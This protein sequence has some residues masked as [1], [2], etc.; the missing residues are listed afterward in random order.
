MGSR[1]ILYLTIAASLPLFAGYPIHIG[2][3]DPVGTATMIHAEG[4]ETS[5]NK[6]MVDGHPGPPQER[7]TAIKVD[8]RREILAANEQRRATR[9]Q[10][11]LGKGTCRVDG[12]VLELPPE[13]SIVE[14]RREAG[15]D[16][17]LKDGFPL[18]E[19][20]Q[21][22]LGL[23]VGLG[24]GKDDDDA[25]YGTDKPREI[26][27]SW[28]VNV[29]NILETAGRAAGFTADPRNVTGKTVFQEVVKDHGVDCI[30]LSIHVDIRKARGAFYL[31]R[32]RGLRIAKETILLEQSGLFPMD[33][34]LQPH[35]YRIHSRME[36]LLACDGK[37]DG[38][39]PIPVAETLLD[40]FVQMD[41]TPL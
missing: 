11:T 3:P 33:P 34:E 27:D 4:S 26:G 24:D 10:L 28:D 2:R 8:Y 20:V 39:E 1:P 19:K 31:D 23:A 36:G 41:I 37:D 25:Q 13:G 29:E 12:Q 9:L 5:I 7:V 14:V 21:D 40:T 30:R 35:A 22:A 17:Y 15:R 18:P 38:A 32:A 6:L 16:L